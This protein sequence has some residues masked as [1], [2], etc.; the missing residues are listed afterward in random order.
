MTAPIMSPHPAGA[1]QMI[2][3]GLTGDTGNFSA[4]TAAGADAVVTFAGDTK[5]RPVNVDG[6]CWSYSDDPVSGL[7]TLADGNGNIYYQVDVIRGGPDNIRFPSPI[8]IPGGVTMAATLTGMVGI[9][10]K[11][12]VSCWRLK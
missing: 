12:Y 5:G 8:M 7:F 3:F 11:L 1:R 4:S 10:G 6:V 9:T 2:A